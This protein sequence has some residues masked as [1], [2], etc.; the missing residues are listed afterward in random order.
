M[1]GITN[2]TEWQIGPVT[3]RNIFGHRTTE[4]STD[5]NTDAVAFTPLPII[6]A[7]SRVREQQT[8]NEF[9]V[10][11]N[12]LDNR[13]DYLVGLFYIKEEP[14]G[15][16]GSI[17]PV[18]SP[19]A[20]WVQ[21]YTEKTNK[22][23]FGQVGY[24]LSEMVNGLKLNV[25]Y[26]YN[27]TEQEVCAVTATPTNIGLMPEPPIGEGGCA[28]HPNG[29]VID[30]TEYANTWNIGLD[31]QIN[32][33]LF[34]YITRRKGYREGGI[35]APAF[36]TSASQV[37]APYQT[38]EPET[39][40]DIEIGL[41]SD[42]TVAQVPVR[43]NIAAY[44]GKYDNVVTNFNTSQVVP[45]SDA[46]APQSSAVAINTGKRTLSG[47]ESE[48]IVEL[49]EGFTISNSTAYTHQKIDESALPP[50]AGLQPPSLDPA[51]P[52]WA[53]TTTIRWVLP[54]RPL[55][56][57]VVLNAEHYWQESY[58]VGNAE[59]PSYD[60]TK[61]RLSWN[62]INQSGLDVSFFMRNVFDDE[63]P[64]EVATTAAS[65]GIYALSYAEP[66]M[67]GVEA[68]YRF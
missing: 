18:A 64:Y 17:F 15:K 20:P 67:Y 6:T 33:H 60:V 14:D 39:L 16:N 65:L 53:T 28:A 5:L 59:L 30:S 21:S 37:L 29:S 26:R 57:E 42:F 35:N 68:T 1:E 38:Y 50:L 58:Y 25:G 19:V 52:E 62:D 31:W 43:F 54:V 44:R 24:D 63:Y 66:R 2:R 61:M 51:S 13:L 55:N 34:T 3:L 41:K 40:K 22:A 23:A 32:D 7:F 4:V 27:E 12:A 46:G 36:N 9:H 48:L 49:F 47:F 45:S 11:G 10:F 8:S 56:G